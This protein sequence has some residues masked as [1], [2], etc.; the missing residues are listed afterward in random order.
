ML[1]VFR[2]NCMAFKIK[3]TTIHNPRDNYRTLTRTHFSSN[4]GGVGGWVGNIYVLLD[5]TTTVHRG[6]LRGWVGSE[7]VRAAVL[8]Y[9]AGD[10]VGV[11]GL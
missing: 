2:L 4:A 10:L 5:Y 9:S 6:C 8:L 1:T 7:R 11:C 3:K